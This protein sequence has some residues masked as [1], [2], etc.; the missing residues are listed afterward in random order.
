M[1]A[2]AI[3]FAW[4]LLLIGAAAAIDACYTTPAQPPAAAAPQPRPPE[5]MENPE[6]VETPPA[7]WPVAPLTEEDITPEAT[8]TPSPT[9]T[10][11]PTETPY[12]QTPAPTATPGPTPTASPLPTLTPE[13]TP[14]PDFSRILPP[15]QLSDQPLTDEINAQ[16]LPT[17]K[18]SMRIADRARRQLHQQ[19]PDEA[20]RT[21]GRAL[22]IDPGD[23][24]VYFYLGRAYLMK[25]NYQQALIFWQR[26]AISF[27]NNPRWLS[28]VLGFEGGVKERLGEIDQ[29]R[30]DFARALQLDPN[31]QLAKDGN[32]RLGPPPPP[33][34]AEPT[35]GPAEAE[36]P[37]E[38]AA[39]PPPPDIG[40][41]P[42]VEEPMPSEAPTPS[43]QGAGETY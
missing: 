34:Q 33:P 18:T 30:E 23:P 41:P 10:A 3:L 42:P 35:E 8:A 38:E 1:P 31:N 16:P 19:Q 36:P 28:E 40:A 21:L 39:P 27:S 24:Y 32:S 13:P 26:A 2:R 6:A 17:R 22:S 5:V 14:Q 25:H 9:E 20:I 15:G 11:T 12:G 29:A 4:A 7:P 43:D 37:P